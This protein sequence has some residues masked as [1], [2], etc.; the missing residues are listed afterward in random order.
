MSYHLEQ[1]LDDD[2]RAEC[3]R[4]DNAMAMRRA[5]PYNT[6][7][8]Q[9]GLTFQPRPPR[10]SAD[11]AAIQAALLEPRTAQPATGLR[12]VLAFLWRLL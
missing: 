4:N 12:R 8:V 5:V 6:G 10:L 3:V 7:R 2:T 9:I 1:L 11:A